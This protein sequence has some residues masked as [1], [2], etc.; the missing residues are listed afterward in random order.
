MQ[1][2]STSHRTGSNSTHGHVLTKSF[3]CQR[4]W[5]TQQSSFN[6]NLLQA[7]ASLMAFDYA[8][9]VEAMQGHQPQNRYDSIWLEVNKLYSRSWGRSSHSRIEIDSVDRLA[10]MQIASQPVWLDGDAVFTAR[11]ML[12]WFPELHAQSNA[13]LAEQF[14]EKQEPSFVVYPNP[15]TDWVHFEGDEDVMSHEVRIMDLTGRITQ[16]SHSEV[17]DGRHA[18]NLYGLT[19]G[20]YIIEIQLLS[21]IKRTKLLKK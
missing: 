3:S 7:N 5:D 11:I 18:I 19:P 10:L 6:Y 15:A 12:N 13:R 8:T 9:Y 16:T 14:F 1:R 2:I 17:I 20:L 4:F 21:G